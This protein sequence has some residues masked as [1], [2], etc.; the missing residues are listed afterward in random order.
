MP[1]VHQQRRCRCSKE[2]I[3]QQ[4]RFLQKIE[5]TLPAFVRTDRDIYEQYFFF[6]CYLLQKIAFYKTVLT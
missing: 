1:P 3:V 2:I 4:N 6:P 5:N